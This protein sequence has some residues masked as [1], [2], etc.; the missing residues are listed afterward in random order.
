MYTV[1]QLKSKLLFSII[2]YYKLAY[3]FIEPWCIL[4][5]CHTDYIHPHIG[6]LHN[7]GKGFDVSRGVD[8]LA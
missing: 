6:T 2:I 1:I 7:P 8:K 3:F 5:L 4:H